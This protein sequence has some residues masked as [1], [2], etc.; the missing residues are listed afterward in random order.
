M[1]PKG[2]FN[3]LARPPHLP[4]RSSV[5]GAV[6]ARHFVFSA[7]NHVCCIGGEEDCSRRDVVQLQP[8]DLEWTVGARLSPACCGVGCSIFCPVLGRESTAAADAFDFLIQRDVGRIAKVLDGFGWAFWLARWLGLCAVIV[9]PALRKS[10]LINR[11][12]RDEDH[13][14]NISQQFLQT[15]PTVLSALLFS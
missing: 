2:R 15:F 9:T 14:P 4:W 1:R 12:H 13:Q 11:K 7:R 6:A 3:I 10:R 8:P 5:L